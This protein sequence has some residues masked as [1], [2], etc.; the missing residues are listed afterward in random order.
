MAA[1]RKATSSSATSAVQSLLC[2]SVSRAWAR[3]RSCRHALFPRLRREG[4]LPVLLRLD[5][6][7]AEP[8]S[9]QVMKSLG[10]ALDTAGLAEV[11]R[12]AGNETLWEYFHRRHNRAAKPV[13]PVLV[14]DQFEELFT[15]GHASEASRARCAALLEEL[16]DLVENRAPSVLEHRFDESPDLVERFVFDRQEYRV[17]LSLREDYLPPLEDIR[18]RM[19]APG[20]KPHA[21]RPHERPAGVRG[22]EQA[23]R[24]PGFSRC[25]PRD[26][27]L[28]GRQPARESDGRRRADGRG[29]PDELGGRAVAPEPVLQRAQPRTPGSRA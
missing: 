20:S 13:V 21:P 9:E 7:H 5:Y 16:A 27:P 25:V 3:H 17:L 19:P 1:S 24:R 15:I 2:Y 10:L 4:F 8:L 6:K 11:P 12:P 14:F 23:R 26:R 22:R 18:A 28:R 29:R